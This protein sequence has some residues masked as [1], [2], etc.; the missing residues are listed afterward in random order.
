[1][2]KHT[3]LMYVI[4]RPT[5]HSSRQQGG[6]GGVVLPQVEAATATL[7]TSPLHLFPAPSLW[8]QPPVST[9]GLLSATMAAAQTSG[10]LA[11][12]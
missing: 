5:R 12:M 1:M 4:A 10:A 2:Y 9:R 7:A 8:A 6:A 11:A 3:Q